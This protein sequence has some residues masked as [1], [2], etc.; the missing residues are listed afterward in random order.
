[1]ETRPALQ[2]A[3]QQKRKRLIL[4]SST[5]TMKRDMAGSGDK[6]QEEIGDPS[7]SSPRPAVKRKRKSAP[8][9]R[10][11]TATIP[12]TWASGGHDDEIGSY[13]RPLK[14]QKTAFTANH[15]AEEAAMQDVAGDE[16]EPYAPDGMKNSPTKAPSKPKKVYTDEEVKYF[17]DGVQNL[18]DWSS[19]TTCG[20]FVELI[21]WID[22]EGLCIEDCG[23]Q[24]VEK[25]YASMYKSYNCHA[26]VF[27]AEKGLVWIPIE[28]RNAYNK[29]M[30]GYGL[31]TVGSPKKPRSTGIPLARFASS[32]LMLERPLTPA[33]LDAFPEHSSNDLIVMSTYVRQNL[34]PQKRRRPKPKAMDT[35]P[36]PESDIAEARLAREQDKNLKQLL[37]SQARPIKRSSIIVPKGK[38]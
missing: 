15:Y 27:Y 6:A 22:V 33:F 32:S 34:K 23:R 28:R 1:M 17:Q 2:E 7:L 36:I 20:K 29:K 18:N 3:A 9:R 35:V 21:R 24:W 12:S 37:L 26:P 19:K 5:A 11:D 13:T 8:S 10:S 25:G 30:R 31:R 14:K 16:I 4:T 38:T